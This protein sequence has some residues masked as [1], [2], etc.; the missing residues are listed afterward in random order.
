MSESCKRT[1]MSEFQKSAAPPHQVHLQ[2]NLVPNKIP[3]ILASCR[4]N[5]HYSQAGSQCNWIQ[6]TL[7]LPRHG[8][9]RDSTDHR[10]TELRRTPQCKHRTKYCRRNAF[11][12]RQSLYNY[13]LRSVYTSGR[14]PKQ[15]CCNQEDTA[16]DLPMAGHSQMI[17]QK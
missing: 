4:R 3:S 10:R 9:L 15:N 7:S 1:R 12:S 13:R 14:H 11:E 17:P 5:R 6:A 16:P 2:R 8:M